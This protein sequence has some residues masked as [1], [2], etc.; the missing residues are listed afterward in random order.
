MM[1]TNYLSKNMIKSTQSRDYSGGMWNLYFL[2]KLYR[3][4]KIFY[5]ALRSV[6]DEFVNSAEKSYT[7]NVPKSRLLTLSTDG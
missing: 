2:G 4:D 3:W 5:W 1:K 7:C 6:E